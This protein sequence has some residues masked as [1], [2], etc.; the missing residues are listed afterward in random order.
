MRRYPEAIASYE[1]ALEI[2]P[3]LMEALNNMG[4]AYKEL[5]ESASAI[6]FYHRALSVARHPAIYHNLGSVFLAA[7]R[8][9]SAVAYFRQAIAGDPDKRESHEGLAKAYR[10]QDRLQ[11]AATVLETALGRWPEDGSLLLLLGDTHA[12]LGRDDA[13]VA[14]YR[15][16]RLSPAAARLRL[17]DAARERGDW[18]RARRHYEAGLSS[19]PDDA[20]LHNALG[21]AL[22][23]EGR[24][25]EALDSYR[26]A[27][28]LDPGLAAAY[29]NI[30]LAYLTHGGRLEAIA[31]LERSAD[32]DPDRAVTWGL[33]ARA[34]VRNERPDEAMRALERAI[35]LSPERAEYHYDL[36]ILYAEAGSVAQAEKAYL[37]A[38]ERDPTHSHVHYN[39]GSLWLE[40]GRF[41]P[42]ARMLQRALELDPER[43]E[44][45]IN[46]AS[47][48]LNLG[49]TPAAIAAY[50][51]YLEHSPPE[52]P[53]RDKVLNQLRL[54]REHLED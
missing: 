31:A 5:G 33:L 25:R 4:N 24:T 30:G 51:S 47:A 50:E 41:A 15:R 20:R 40:Q 36:G 17:A 45:Y 39:L 28:E 23:H 10:S 38:V 26:R 49:D 48:H 52:S 6:G 44:V 13:A 2:R 22:F 54:L 3:K 34:Y 29:T 7:A 35:D 42:A 9:D 53:H 43:P 19:H 18:E 46:L 37:A 16:A 8:L 14:A 11:S 21:E 27:A 32:I 12:S 1:R